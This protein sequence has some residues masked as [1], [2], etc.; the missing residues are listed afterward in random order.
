MKEQLKELLLEALEQ[1][2]V[3][4]S[5][6]EAK[7]IIIEYPDFKFGHYSTNAAL[8]IA[9][10]MDKKPQEVAAMIIQNIH[11]TIFES[12]TLAT[13]GFINFKIS[14]NFFLLKTAKLAEEGVKS[15]AQ[16]KNQ[17][18]LV[19]YFQPNIAKPLHIGHLRTAIIGDCIRRMYNF[20]GFATESDTHMGDW[21]TQFGL[22]ILAY[23]NYLAS[24]GD[25]KIIE[26]DPIN[27]LN[28]LYIQINQGIENNKILHEQGK[29]EFVKLEQSDPENRKIWKQFVEWSMEKFL[30]IN[31]LMD[32]LPFDHHWPESFYEDK[33][34]EVIQKLKAK[35]LLVESQGAQIVNLS[36]TEGTAP[37]EENKD[38]GV[39]IIIK[40]DG[41]TTYLLRDLATFIFRKQQGFTK[42]LYV[43]D[44]R[45]SHS[46]DQLFAILEKMEEIPPLWPGQAGQAEGEH[47]DYGFISFKGEA[48]S[49]RKGNMVLA[50]EVLREAEQR[51]AKVIAQ[52]NP[53]LANKP[54]V[55]KDVSK[56]ALKY[57]DLSH[58]RH[59]DIAFDWDEV[60]DFEGNSGPYLQYAYARL[61]SILRKSPTFPLATGGQTPNS[62]FTTETE[63]KIMFLLSIFSEKVRES[64]AQFL[65]NIFANYLYELAAL[66][67]K[68]YHESPVLQE[69][70][71]SAKIFRL[72]LV[73]A[74]KNVLGKGLDILGIKALEEM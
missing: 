28:K 69:Q 2:G 18:I 34:P 61:A 56:A 74:S 11:S 48:L 36:A 63:Q 24:G 21:G 27:E 29:L 25:P 67:N 15:L 1:M 73:K 19:E 68:F 43:V 14:Q 55:I 20:L 10:M 13:P 66:L 47:I 4:L 32:I 39:A 51:V 31:E 37:G 23:K 17:K 62:I 35:K 33:M 16:I 59:S 57:F 40:S 58:N 5:L 70:N 6:S 71:E 45:Q 50:E 53:D 54:A 49:T 41:G 65:P 46:F 12:I 42:Q 22:L 8:I 7:K 30:R 9:K 44:N 26:Q 72:C 52:K 64:L 3:K 38:L 60:L